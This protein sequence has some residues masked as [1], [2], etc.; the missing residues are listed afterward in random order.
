MLS[1]SANFAHLSNDCLTLE[2]RNLP[3]LVTVPNNPLA[4][5]VMFDPGI[6]IATC[7]MKVSNLQWETFH[8]Q[9]GEGGVGH[10]EAGGSRSQV[11]R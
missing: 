2:R 11:K 5:L 10:R 6:F 4:E 8:L 7:Q 9:C 3:V 1:S